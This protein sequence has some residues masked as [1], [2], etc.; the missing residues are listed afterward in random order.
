M[1]LDLK[2]LGTKLFH[3][4]DRLQFDLN[5]VAIKTGITTERIKSIKEGNLEPTG[6]EILIFADFYKEDYKY[7][8]SNQQ[9][10]SSEQVDI[11]YRKF[12]DSFSKQD[13]WAIQ[14]F[15]Y[16]C[17]C[18]EF[19]LR[20]LDFNKKEF[21]FHKSGNFYKGH[22]KQAAKGLRE[23]LGYNENDLLQNIFDDFRKI[24]V[25]IFR[26]K[27]YNSKISG[28]F[29]LHPYAGKCV[30]VN[31]NEDTYRQN[32]TLAHEVAHSIFDIEEKYNVSF[33]NDGRDLREIRA[34]TFASNFLIPEKAIKDLKV[35][36]W[37]I[38]TLKRI[39][40]QL[41]VNI[42]PLLIKLKELNLITTDQYNIFNETTI[43]KLDKEDFELEGLSE[44]I[45]KK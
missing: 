3:C 16:L 45:K 11:L 32:F 13:R 12:G 30:L 6:D 1:S 9:K 24:G 40:N 31:Y 36:I 41:K 21:Q 43:N 22:G 17:E 29:V 8:V 4:R 42:T 38:D 20:E 15:L 18:E 25:H 37:S 39:A 27:L 26:R 19:V 7:F 44:K 35:I 10:S 33:I 28:L 2:F 34:N 5:E 23:F 14:E